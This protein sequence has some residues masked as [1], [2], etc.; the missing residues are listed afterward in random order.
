VSY[1]VTVDGAF[2]ITPPASPDQQAVVAAAE[3]GWRIS[4]NGALLYLPSDEHPDVFA[5]IRVL[6]AEVLPS[7]GLVAAGAVTWHG[8]DGAQG[9]IRIEGGQVTISEP[10]L[11]R[12]A[13]EEVGRLTRQLAAGSE[14]EKLE[15][16]EVLEFFQVSSPPVVEALAGA[17]DD[18]SLQVRTRAANALASLGPL[19]LPALHALLL[20]LR[21]SDQW[22][23]CAAAEAIG[24]IGPAAAE[25]LP[26]LRELQLHPSYGP[27][28]R[29]TEAIARLTGGTSP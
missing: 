11:E 1:L 9:E 2:T 26:A 7:L 10:P 5:A 14:A 27:S 8:E 24:A 17:L 4:P 29:A 25:A 18:S 6:L 22:V 3:R 19:A 16:V 23:Q 15:A 20:A 21:Q 12:P 28:G 13:H